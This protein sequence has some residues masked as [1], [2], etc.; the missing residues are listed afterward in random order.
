MNL[1]CHIAASSPP[2]TIPKKVLQALDRAIEVRTAHNS[3]FAR[4]GPTSTSAHEGHVY[5]VAVLKKVRNVL[6]PVVSES[7]SGDKSSNTTDDLEDRFEEL[8]MED[9]DEEEVTESSTKLPTS[10]ATTSDVN[11]GIESKYE[12]IEG[13]FSARCF[14]KDLDK[15]T[16]FVTQV[17]SDSIDRGLDFASAAVTINTAI[18]LIR[19][20]EES[21]KK[22]VDKD[23]E[24]IIRLYYEGCCIAAGLDPGHKDAPTFHST[25]MRSM[26]QSAHVFLP[27]PFC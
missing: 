6:R 21:L 23:C 13:Y 25:S 7:G 11:Y 22:V 3:W 15:L 14:F 20:I 2:T 17:W 16:E 4:S 18:D 10:N 26:Q 19:F 24:E 1:A 12:I 9:M 5:F 27:T 8:D